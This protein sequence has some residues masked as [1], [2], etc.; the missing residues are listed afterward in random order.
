MMKAVN[1]SIVQITHVKVSTNEMSASEYVPSYINHINLS[2]TTTDDE[3][4]LKA[5]YFRAEQINKQT[6]RWIWLEDIFFFYMDKA[7]LVFS[8]HQVNTYS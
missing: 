8:T 3:G 2:Y 5:N 6:V 1:I 7:T 4:Q